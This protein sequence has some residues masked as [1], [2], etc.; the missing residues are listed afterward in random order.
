MRL[1]KIEKTREALS[2]PE[3]PYVLIMTSFLKR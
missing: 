2:T 3:V 1:Q